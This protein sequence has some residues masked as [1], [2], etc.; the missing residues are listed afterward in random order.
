MEKFEKR[1]SRS[2]IFFICIVLTIPNNLYRKKDEKEKKITSN[3]KICQENYE[4]KVVLTSSHFPKSNHS[5][6]SP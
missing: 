4:M 3:N 5:N 2:Y 1:W 6:N